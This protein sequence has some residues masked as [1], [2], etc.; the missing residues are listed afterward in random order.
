VQSKLYP[1][2]GVYTFGQPR[3]GNAAFVDTYSKTVREFRVVHF[4]DIVAQLPLQE[5]G[6]KHP[7]TE[8]CRARQCTC[9]T[10][11]G[12]STLFMVYIRSACGDSS[13]DAR[14]KAYMTELAHFRDR[15]S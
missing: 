4:Q 15:V 9:C 10:G 12:Y 8:V 7:A 2:A 11:S 5:M 14:A 3:V 6:F 1:I 13:C